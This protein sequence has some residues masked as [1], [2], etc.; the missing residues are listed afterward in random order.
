M[1]FQSKRRRFLQGALASLGAISIAGCD[2]LSENKS[3]L[4]ALGLGAKLNKTAQHAVTTR[5]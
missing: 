4:K 5:A 3:F 1:K 2:A